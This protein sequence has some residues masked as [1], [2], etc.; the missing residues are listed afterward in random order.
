M[1]RGSP[2]SCRSRL[3]LGALEEL[4]ALEVLEPLEMLERLEELE[5]L[6]LLISNPSRA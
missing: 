4:E 5:S 3:W 2:A 1:T 6:E